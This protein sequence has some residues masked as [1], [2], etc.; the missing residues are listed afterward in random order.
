MS[1][2]SG[3]KAV[4]K[5]DVDARSTVD[6][7]TACPVGLI[8]ELRR[9]GPIIPNVNHDSPGLRPDRCASIG[10]GG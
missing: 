4:N 9:R 1:W 5:V 10:L 6:D 3:R 2:I 7:G 8:H